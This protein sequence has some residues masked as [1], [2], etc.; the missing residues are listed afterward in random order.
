MINRR[1]DGDTTVGEGEK[2]DEVLEIARD[3]ANH[4]LADTR[5]NPEVHVSPIGDLKEHKDEPGDGTTC[6][7]KPKRDAEHHDVIVHNSMDGREAY[8]NGRLKH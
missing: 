3:E 5:D 4:P 1:K 6:W 8:E 2:L 7:C